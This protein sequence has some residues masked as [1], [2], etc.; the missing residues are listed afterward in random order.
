MNRPKASPS[1]LVMS[2]SPPKDCSGAE[3]PLTL[4]T[5]RCTPTDESSVRCGQITAYLFTP[6]GSMFSPM[7]LAS[8]TAT[9]YPSFSRILR[10]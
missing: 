7:T 8:A 1:S 9:N 6:I 3:L 10:G 4:E 5:K 2:G